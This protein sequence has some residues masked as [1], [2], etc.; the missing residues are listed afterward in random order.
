M[1]RSK[2]REGNKC[3]LSAQVMSKKETLESA[4]A[5]FWSGCAAHVC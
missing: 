5:K 4:T 1:M 2:L 3:S